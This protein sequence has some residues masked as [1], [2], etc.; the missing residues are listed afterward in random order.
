MAMQQEYSNDAERR[1]DLM[2]SPPIKE[3][4]IPN[5]WDVSSGSNSNGCGFHRHCSS[6]KSCREH[7]TNVNTTNSTSSSYIPSLDDES[8]QSSFSCSSM[9][10]I[11]YDDTFSLFEKYAREE[12]VSL[13]VF[14]SRSRQVVE[15]DECPMLNNILSFAMKL[16]IVFVMQSFRNSTQWGLSSI[17]IL[18]F[19]ES[20][21]AAKA[22]QSFALFVLLFGW[23]LSCQHPPVFSFSLV[24]RS[25]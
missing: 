22:I 13:D 23:V 25:S 1:Q 20:S 3:I 12:P 6:H 19:D 4:Y 7:D 10:E 17:P 2:L 11:C 21:V 24:H 16:C 5:D 18:S 14:A 15:A 8:C 9:S